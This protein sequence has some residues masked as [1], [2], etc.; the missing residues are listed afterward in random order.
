MDKYL[1]EILSES[2]TIIIPGLGALTITNKDTGETMFMPYLQHDDGK[3]AEFIAA[4]DGIDLADAKIAVAKYVRAIQVELD[5]GETY[6]MFQLGTFVKVAGDIEFSHWVGGSIDNPAVEEV[7]LEETIVEAETVAEPEILPEPDVE[8]IHEPIVEDQIEPEE[9]IE[10]EEPASVAEAITVIT[11]ISEVDAD[12]KTET[13]EIES[14][15]T[16]PE[17]EQINYVEPQVEQEI[18]KAKSE[19]VHD[20][21]IISKEEVLVKTPVET[22]SKEKRSK[23]EKKEKKKR[24]IGFWLLMVVIVGIVGGGVYFAMNY[25]DLRQH[26]PFLADKKEKVIESSEAK[27]KME[28][29][30]NG[31]EEEEISGTEEKIEE[32]IVEEEVTEEPATKPVVTS[33]TP[34][35]SSNGSYHIVSGA[36]SSIDNANRLMESFKSQGL[37]ARIIQNNG[38]NVVCMQ[39][40]AT[41][42]QAQAD[43]SNMKSKAASCWILYKP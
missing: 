15:L 2:N 34:V 41:S 23:P 36:F 3:L 28:E 19:P 6:N 25:D 38:L 7:V 42:A 40:Y 30:L 29:I 39:S 22:P 31:P 35:A 33:P 14:H 12:S 18:I 37:P 1:L 20:E 43:L 24:G 17:V 16:T 13:A 10:N 26:I 5:K 32:P 21:P 8:V 9:I 4:K 27:K 11:P